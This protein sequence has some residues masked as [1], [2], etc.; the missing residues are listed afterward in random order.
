MKKAWRGIHWYKVARRSNMRQFI[1]DN[2]DS[3]DGDVF[4][5]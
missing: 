5:P 3:Y 1:Q 2:Y 4:L